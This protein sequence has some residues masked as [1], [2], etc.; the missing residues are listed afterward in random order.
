MILRG[1]NFGPVWGASGVQGFFGEGYWYHPWLRPIGLNFQDMTFVAKTTTLH[2]QMGN[3]PMRADGITPVEHSP[4]CIAVRP[5]KGVALNAVGLSGPGAGAL[6]D[7]GIWQSMPYPFLLSFMSVAQTLELRLDELRA[8]VH[9]LAAARR[10]FVSPF[11]LQLNVSCPNVDVAHASDDLAF[12]LTNALDIAAKLDIP[13]IPKLNVLAPLSIVPVLER[14]PACDGVCISNTLPWHSLPNEVDWDRLWSNGSPL[15]AR[16]LKAP[17]GLSGRPL[18]PLVKRWVEAAR[19]ISPSL[20]INAGGGIL[21]P[22]DALV[23]LRAGANS[24]FIG[25]MA[26]LR[27]WNVART[28]RAVHV[29]ANHRGIE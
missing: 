21:S 7:Q 22:A 3:M 14:H 9:L 4:S 17:G 6:L 10:D 13:L 27:P 15:I 28:I 25:S 29:W 16:G 11:G 12:E 20:L 24:I 1:I 18:L 8:F 26:F 5:L 23:L 2:A 19:E